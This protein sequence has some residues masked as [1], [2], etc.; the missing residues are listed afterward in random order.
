MYVKHQN[1]NFGLMFLKNI[2]L[3]VEMAFDHLPLSILMRLF[4][5]KF[6]PKK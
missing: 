5:T 1:F 6:E 4:V 3:C 2:T